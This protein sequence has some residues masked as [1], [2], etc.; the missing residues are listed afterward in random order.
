MRYTTEKCVLVVEWLN[1][2]TAIRVGAF[3]LWE[4]LK[5]NS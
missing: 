4:S 1:V 5:K 2:D 3:V